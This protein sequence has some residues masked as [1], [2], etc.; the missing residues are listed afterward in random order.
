METRLQDARHG[1]ARRQG[2]D[3]RARTDN[4]RFTKQASRIYRCRW[5]SLRAELKR[6]FPL[7]LYAGVR[8]CRCA[9]PS[10]LPSPLTHRRAPS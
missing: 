5:L 8:A 9:L 7:A 4:L 2:A 10:L 1:L 3:G 6:F